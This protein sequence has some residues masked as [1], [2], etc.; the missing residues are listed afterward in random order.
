MKENDP[1]VQH[2]VKFLLI[3]AYLRE[4]SKDPL[5]DKYIPGYLTDVGDQVTIIGKFLDRN[6][7]I[8]LK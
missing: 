8:F 3:K 1:F 7:V 4:R 6:G 5:I 2:I